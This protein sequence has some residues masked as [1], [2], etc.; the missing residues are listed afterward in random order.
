MAAKT[1]AK[2]SKKEHS[3]L[4]IVESPAKAKTIEKY[5]GSGYTVKASMGHL[6]D[7]PKSRMAVNIEKN[8]EP[9][10]ITVRGRAP[11]L[12]DLQK[13]AKKADEVLLAFA[14]FAKCKNE[15]D[16]KAYCI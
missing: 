16:D 5:L 6:I 3:A 4:I 14:Q 1:G 11:I 2:K 7:L 8:F 10:Y 9:E 12:K 13:D 15:C